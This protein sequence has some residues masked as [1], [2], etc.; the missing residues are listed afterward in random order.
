MDCSSEG[1]RKSRGKG[2]GGKQHSKGRLEGEGS[3]IEKDDP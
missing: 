3:G 1:K 2:R